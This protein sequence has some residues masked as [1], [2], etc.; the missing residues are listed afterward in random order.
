MIF[1]VLFDIQTLL[2]YFF[3][4]LN[5]SQDYKSMVKLVEDVSHFPFIKL[6]SNQ[7]I[8]NLYAFALNR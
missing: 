4:L 5:V 1:K 2:F 7:G 3:K 8:Q 6:E